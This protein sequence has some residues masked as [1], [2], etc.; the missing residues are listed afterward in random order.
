MK[1]VFRSALSV[2]MCLVML[3]G[4]G[5]VGASA[6]NT[7]GNIHI[8]ANDWRLTSEQLRSVY[9]VTNPD[10]F[11]ALEN[12]GIEFD[13][14]F[15]TFKKPEL[16]CDI[17]D[18]LTEEQ[19]MSAAAI[20]KNT[21]YED[22]IMWSLDDDTLWVDGTG[23]WTSRFEIT[24]PWY[25]QKDSI[26]KAV[27][28]ENV[29]KINEFG[30][31]EC[32]NLETV[33]IKGNITLIDGGAFSGCSKLKN[34]NLPDS[35]TAIEYR[36]FEN[37][38][39]LQAIYIPERVTG[40]SN[41]AFNGCAPYPLIACKSGS[42]A[43]QFARE[44]SKN[45]YD[46]PEFEE[47]KADYGT[48]IEAKIKL[49]YMPCGCEAYI[50]NKNT[51]YANGYLCTFISDVKEDVPVTVTIRHG[52]V[53]VAEKTTKIIVKHDIFSIIGSWFKNWLFTPFRWKEDVPVVINYR[54]S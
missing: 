40:I 28:G 30:F 36:A 22:F 38:K 5:A 43:E 45:L 27:V 31:S 1:K 15:N 11:S 46:L 14:Y 12:Q 4:I 34:I 47:A 35:L 49:P 16:P 33:E 48:C 52:N 6:E 21:G 17:C 2:L 7:K 3:Y 20:L 39:S 25:S 44:N 19:A 32:T 18:D 51:A 42:Y 24:I 26:K 9:S 8:Y 50:N 41:D 23:G 13:D 10:I 54:N 37:C 29:T 53:T